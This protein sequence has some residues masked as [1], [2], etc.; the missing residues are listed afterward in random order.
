M[1]IMKDK[2]KIDS[3]IRGPEKIAVKKKLISQVDVS[4]SDKFILVH[5]SFFCNFL[6]KQF[7]VFVLKNV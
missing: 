6:K 2:W 3:G 5:T 1:Q 4:E 7:V